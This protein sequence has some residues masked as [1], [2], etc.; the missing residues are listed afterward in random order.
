[1]PEFLVETY[2][3]YEPA[4]A[5]AWVQDVSLAADQ[6]SAAGS[7][8]RLQSVIFVPE[9][10][11][12]FYLF[13]AS[14]TDAVRHAMPRAGVRADRIAEPVSAETKAI[15]VARS[16]ERMTFVPDTARLN[17]CSRPSGLGRPQQQ[18]Q[19]QNQPEDTK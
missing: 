8:V 9:D 19:T 15:R 6:L 17:P 18:N 5:S 4:G 12:S 16:E 13:E 11:S 1:M 3:P 7:F 2:T 14:S 10:D